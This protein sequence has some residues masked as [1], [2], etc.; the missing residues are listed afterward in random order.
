MKKFTRLSI[1]VGFVALLVL[2]VAG[3][4]TASNQVSKEAADPAPS[5]ADNAVD[6]ALAFLQDNAESLGLERADLQ[7]VVVTD[8]YVSG[9]SGVTHIYLRQRYNGVELFGANFN[10]NVL[11][12]GRVLSYG[13][14]FIPYLSQQIVGEEPTLSPSEAVEQAAAH[15]GLAAPEGLT[16]EQEFNSESKT[17]LF[18]AGNLSHRA[19]PVKL[20]YQPV[21]KGQIELAW[22]VSIDSVESADYWQTRVSALDGRFLDQNNLTVHET[23]AAYGLVDGRNINTTKTAVVQ[24]FAAP[25]QFD[26][27]G[28]LANAYFVYPPPL[29]SPNHANPPSPPLSED[30]RVLVVDPATSASPFGWHDTNGVA[31][32]EFTITRGNN[33]WAY[34][35]RD[36]NNASAG[37]EPDGGAS[38]VFSDTLDLTL[39]PDNYI[40]AAVTNLFFWNNVIHD[41]MYEYG[42]D[43]A[44]GNF[45][46]N[47]YGNGGIGSDYVI[48]EAQDNADGGSNCN[49]NFSTPTDGGNGRM[50]MY[51][52]NG[53]SPVRDGDLDNGVI[54][55]EYGHGISI[56]LTGGP[57]TS[58]C[59]NNSEQGG[60]GW[61]DWFALMMT[62]EA[63]DASTDSRGIGTY[64]LGE[65]TNGPG[66]R[67]AP[68]STD[69]G[70][71]NYTY[72]DI[73]S[74]A[75]P[76]G[77]GFVWATVL[78]DMS[79]GLID[80]HGFDSDLYTG[81][82]GNNL[83]LQLVMDALKLQTCSP[84][85]LD[86]RDAILDADVA[87]TGGQNACI[88]W[89][90]FA[91]RGMG[92]SADQGSNSN[93]DE[94]EAFDLPELCLQTLKIEKTAN[95]DPVT[96]GQVM[97]YTLVA[98]NDTLGT[99]TDV[100]ITDTVPMY[101]TYITGTASDGGS[102]SGGVVTYPAVT[103]NTG[104]SITRT[105]LV[106][107]DTG[108]GVETAWSDDMESGDTNWAVSHDTNETDIDWTLGTNNP[109]SPT[110]A[111]FAQ[112]ISTV[113]DQYLDFANEMVIPS[114]AELHVWHHYDTESTFDGGVIE[115]STNSG[116]TWQDLGTYMTQNGYNSTIS[117]NW[118]SPIGG[119]EAFSG[120][121]GGYVE[122]VIDL[123]SFAGESALIRFRMATDVSVSANGWFVDDV[124]ISRATGTDAIDNTACVVAFEGD[125]ACASTSTPVIFSDV[126]SYVL[127]IVNSGNGTTTPA[128][129]AHVY[130]ADTMVN[131]TATAGVDASF[132]H[133]E[134]D[135]SGS[136]PV[137]SVTMDGDK[138]VTA[139]FVDEFNT[140][141][142]IVIS[143]D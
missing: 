94:T 86:A 55:H 77:V 73:G 105:F 75:V 108:I 76:H 92:F 136:N 130:E 143:G 22:E 116:G 119:R 113:S 50:Q 84:G 27:E 140:Y 69:M 106:Q 88:I 38:L 65:D 61:S 74:L 127:T 99:L 39:T 110:H 60:E 97:T 6:I 107:V 42:F 87:L 24:G 59:L 21:E 91:N 64:L 102:V 114:L 51:L 132:S 35:D 29:E 28:G 45:Q 52:C 80:E 101:T 96:A 8:N 11:P 62:I 57:G 79:W 131:I 43:E 1:V 85:F 70:V 48:A 125:S 63:G 138:M 123:S 121:S 122:T 135:A 133:W 46:E 128:A 37:D 16:V 58:S 2:F 89:E 81:T 3:S 93:G 95:P 83:A 34:Q 14:R 10:I 115:I 23:V 134:G 100:T 72:E 15:N 118:G 111:W 129:G 4:I 98:T 109:N 142:P 49:A 44:S 13:N 20:V 137:V 32:A 90:A 31:G 19:I 9:H 126:V 41:V 112:D 124:S 66:V 68:Y 139:V 40:P 17:I 7:D 103:L 104:E 141:L 117:N 25:P 5:A 47:N 78:W 18:S 56:R 36:G 71:N 54:I 12:D 26:S 53:G 120:N 67:P 33:V 82:G 30:N